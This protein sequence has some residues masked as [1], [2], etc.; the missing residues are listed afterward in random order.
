MCSFL[1]KVDI[2]EFILE[3]NFF[4]IDSLFINYNLIII[5]KIDN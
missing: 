1:N 2:I 5:L 4:K 3:N